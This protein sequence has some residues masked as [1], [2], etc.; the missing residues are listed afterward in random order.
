VAAARAERV[1]DGQE[2]FGAVW[3]HKAAVVGRA[4]APGV[5]PW[6][7]DRE[8]AVCKCAAHLDGIRERKAKVGLLY[9]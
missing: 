4:G 9:Y 2:H 5:R 1:V 3:Q 8:R 7:Q 6:R